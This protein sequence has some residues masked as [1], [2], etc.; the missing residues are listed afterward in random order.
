VNFM[1]V[2]LIT[3]EGGGI[4]S[5]CYGLAYN[6]SKKKIRTTI[7]TETSG[8]RKVEK[9]NEFLDVKRLYRFDL[10]PRSLWFQIQNFRFLSKAFKDYTLVHGVSPDAS[11]AF[12]FYKRKLRKP[13]IASF[14]AVPLSTAKSYLNVPISSWTPTEVAHHILE[15]PLHDFTIRRCIADADHIIT[16][17]FTTLN[18]FR[19]A[20]KD[21]SL[22]KTSVIYNSL[23]FDEIEDVKIPYDARNEQSSPS[24]IFAGRLFWLKGPMYLLKAFKMLKEDFKDITLKI[25]GKGP[26]ENRMNRFIS[27]AGLKNYVC[28]Y[29]RVPHRNLIAEIKKSDVVVL[30]SVYEA[31]S[32]FALEAMACKKPLI[33]LNIPSTREIIEDGRNGLLAKAFDVKDFAY[34]IG[35]VLSDKKL[36]FRLGQNAYKYVKREH[37]WETQIEKYLDVYRAVI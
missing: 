15:Y 35:L 37:N 23:N 10:P 32:M 11:V 13:V 16:C 12:T 28:F 18:E 8:K 1:R 26:E 34:K 24:I 31:Q 33:A 19:A 5:V 17:S 21:L 4:S 7:F 36:R 6:L 30:P 3:L 29:G 2:A 25:F 22:E 27:E 20:Y 14:H 9:L